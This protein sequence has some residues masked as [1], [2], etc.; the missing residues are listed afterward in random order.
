MKTLFKATILSVPK[1][2]ALT[3]LALVMQLISRKVFKTKTLSLITKTFIDLAKTVLET[4][5]HV[6]AT[7][8]TLSDAHIKE[9]KRYVSFRPSEAF[10]VDS[11]TSITTPSQMSVPTVV[12]E[13]EQAM[14]NLVIRVKALEESQKSS[15]Q[16]L[17]I[18]N[19]EIKDYQQL[20]VDLK[21]SI[22]AQQE[23]TSALLK[24]V[25]SQITELNAAMSEVDSQFTSQNAA[26]DNSQRDLV[27]TYR[28][29]S[30]LHEAVT[31]LSLTVVLKPTSQPTEEIM[32]TLNEYRSYLNDLDDNSFDDNEVEW[33]FVSSS[34]GEDFLKDTLQHI[35]QLLQLY[36]VESSTVSQRNRMRQLPNSES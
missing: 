11:T 4:F 28:L 8:L 22:T 30:W 20:F 25:Q 35:L 7:E 24:T 16:A 12:T 31:R 10:D 32:T 5:P 14:R 18:A 19:H 26:I 33:S 3:L 13:S 34:Q 21:Q 9:L 1:V 27:E 23:A 2:L 17:A 15:E 6:S 36:N 29:V